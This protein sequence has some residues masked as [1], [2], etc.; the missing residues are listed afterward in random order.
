MLF[1]RAA[2]NHVLQFFVST[3]PEHF[4]ASA[5]C[6]SRAKILVHDITQLLELVGCATRQHCHQFLSHQIGNSTRKCVFLE[7]SH[8]AQTVAHFWQTNSTILTPVGNLDHARWSS[9]EMTLSCR[10]NGYAPD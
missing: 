1:H 2:C 5:R 9:A 8:K 3:Q 7:N 10:F 4:L 6:V